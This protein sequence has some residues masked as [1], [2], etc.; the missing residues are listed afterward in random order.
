M[1]KVLT[2]AEADAIFDEAVHLVIRERER[3]VLKKGYTAAHDDQHADEEMAAAAAY[4]LLPQ[5][6]NQDVCTC[7]DD[8]SMQVQ[9]LHD[10]IGES[11]WSGLHRDNYD[12]VSVDSV[13]ADVIRIDQLVKGL[14]L[15]VA[16]LERW[17]R[18]KAMR[19][20]VSPQ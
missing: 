8:Y 1:A 6:L 13:E 20:T 4:F 5:H 17:L 19:G 10:V 14:A 11:A 15:G 3:Q 2:P 9:P 12:H 7:R 18:A 16:E